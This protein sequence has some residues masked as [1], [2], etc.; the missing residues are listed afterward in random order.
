MG[1]AA[2]LPAHHGLQVVHALDHPDEL[3]GLH[4]VEGHGA[5]HPLV[6]GDD[7]PGYVPDHR[8]LHEAGL[9]AVPVQVVLL[10]TEV[11][12]VLGQR[13]L[14]VQGQQAVLQGSLDGCF[15]G[16]D[17]EPVR[18]LAVQVRLPDRE[19]EVPKVAVP[20]LDRYG[21]AGPV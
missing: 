6:L 21:C 7:A 20:V 16:L 1:R 3:L 17:E 19:G 14:L 15:P 9:D 12:G 8:R 18:L 2:A 11:G 10:Q 13:V 5:V 4:Q